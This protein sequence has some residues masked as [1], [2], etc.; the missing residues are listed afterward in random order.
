MENPVIINK[1]GFSKKYVFV[2]IPI[3]V[4]VVLTLLKGLTVI[5]AGN[6]GVTTL[7]GKVSEKPLSSGLHLINPLRMVHKMSVRTEEYTMSISGEYGEDDSIWALTKEGLKVVLDI[8]VL[9]HLD[10]QKA[11]MV[12]R[13][14]GD[15]YQEKVIRPAIRTAI[16]DV[17][18]I[19]EAKDIY[20][21]KRQEVAQ[22]I[23]QEIKKVEDRGVVI[24][25]V[26]LRNVN[27]PDELSKSIESKLKAEQEAQAMD[28]VLQKE[29]KEADRKSIEAEG[30][31]KAQDVI[32]RSLTPS[33]LRWY[34]IEMMRDLADSPN[35]TFLFVP[36]DD[37]GMPIINVNP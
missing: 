19:Y 24:E 29:K 11:P 13:D 35:S 15:N 5:P 2:A 6:T 12:Y 27:L 21:E 16:R 25:N 17:V 36:T 30:I 3:I 1:F 18:A 37:N 28:F 33:Y 4:L 14:L 9:Y 26:L 32:S 22:K 23:L 7:F 20:S 34:S 31:K 10:E 8:T